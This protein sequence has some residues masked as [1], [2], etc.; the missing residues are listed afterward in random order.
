MATLYI[1]YFGGADK[2]CAYD[3]IAAETV[4]T[5]TTNAQSTA[6]VRSA[7]VAKI[8][9]DTAHYIKDGADPTATA[10]SGVYLGANEILW[11]RVNRG[12][13]IGAITLA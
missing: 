13:K 8:Q 2:H 11:L 5:S 12:Y 4:T 3:P 6:N 9:S 10:A 1:S 7:C